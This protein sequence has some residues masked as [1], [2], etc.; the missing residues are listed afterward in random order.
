[1]DA[2]ALLGKR[3]VD[4]LCHLS[5]ILEGANVPFAVIGASALFLHGVDLGRETRDLDL[6]VAVNGGL[7]TIRP[8][9]SDA[10]LASTSI[11]HRFRMTDGSEIDILAIDPAWTPAHEIRLADGDRIYAVGLPDAVRESVRI[12]LATCQV[13]VAPLCL[14]IAV[15]LYA[16]TAADRPHDIDDACA[17]LQSYELSG[18]RRFTID[19][20][21]FP[22]LAYETAGAFLAGLDTTEVAP[23]ETTK[24]LHIA[25]DELLTRA[26]LS[27][28]FAEGLFLRELILI[29]RR[30]LEQ[31]SGSTQQSSS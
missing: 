20:E 17:A 11:E 22:G 3:A 5:E 1:M 28:R 19:Y 16:A 27:D 25:I 2:V 24:L 9:L 30:G 12:D 10:G 29:Y 8:L 23:V 15:K 18:D 4:A 13:S 7:E 6:A 31:V 21:R 14:L 26:R